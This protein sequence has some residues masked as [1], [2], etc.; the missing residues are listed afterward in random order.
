M[1]DTAAHVVAHGEL[2]RSQHHENGV[3]DFLGSASGF[4]FGTPIAADFS[5]E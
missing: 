5:F 4:P 2:P 1:L 3:R